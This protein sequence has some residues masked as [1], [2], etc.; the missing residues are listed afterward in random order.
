MR[1]F[2][3]DRHTHR[4]YMEIQDFKKSLR[5]M[6]LQEKV[7]R[8]ELN[9]GEKSKLLGWGEGWQGEMVMWSL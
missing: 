9:E 8:R 2:R 4:S 7:E 6:C 5:M 1:H 3:N